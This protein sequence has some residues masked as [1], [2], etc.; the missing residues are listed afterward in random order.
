MKILIL[1][2]NYAPEPVGIGPYTTGLA[3]GLAERGHEVRVLSG[4]PYY[5]QWRLYAGHSG[6]RA[7]TVEQGVTVTR[8]P[9]YIPAHPSGARRLLHHA[10]FAASVHG[11]AMAEARRRPDL[12]LAIA[13]SLMSVPVA[14]RAARR[15]GAPLWV[16]IQDFEVDAAF[17]TGLI[18]GTAAR[19][20]VWAR[21]RTMSSDASCAVR[22][23]CRPSAR[24]CAPCCRTR[25]CRVI[26]FIRCATGP[27]QISRAQP[28]IAV[29]TV[30][31][32]ILGIG[33][34]PCIPAIS[35][36]SRGWRW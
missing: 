23:W 25:V 15:A 1:G 17:A 29:R 36:T 28:P 18:G 35:P 16:H 7:T 33:M 21:R 31:N 3:E 5:P 22:M 32:G 19:R 6:H 12:V 4:V 13:P 11:D 26:A 27:M 8:V 24:K 30:R 14:A 10:S 34:W 20:H 2:L 9:H